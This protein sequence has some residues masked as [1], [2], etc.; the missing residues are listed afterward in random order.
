MGLTQRDL[1]LLSGVSHSTIAR[2]E[3]GFTIPNQLQMLKI[4]KAL[5]K[6]ILDV[7]VLDWKSLR[8]EM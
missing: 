6:S 8:D 7:F 5:N 1:A 2:I 4:S 3:N